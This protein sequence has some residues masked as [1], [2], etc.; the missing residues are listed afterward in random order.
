VKKEIAKND[1]AEVL[2]GSCELFI[3]IVHRDGLLQFGHEARIDGFAAFLAGF[4]VSPERA[5]R[6]VRLVRFAERDVEGRDLCV[7]LMQRIEQARE[8]DARERPF[9]E[10]LLR[11]LIDIDDGDSWIDRGGAGRAIPETG[12]ER[13]VFE[14]LEKIEQW[15]GAFTDEREVVKDEAGDRDAEADQ[16][17]D[18]MLP[19]GEE[20]F[21]DA[22]TA[23]ALRPFRRSIG[24]EL[25]RELG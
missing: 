22:K 1:G 9:A 12:V 4:E 18:A 2:D 17:R 6:G 13:G 7:F 24:H 5:Q 23:A 8:M 20:Q 11:M 25:L 10:N 21:I 3:G 14:A 19:P 15:S 16:E